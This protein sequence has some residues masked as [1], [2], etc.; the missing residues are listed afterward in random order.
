MANVSKLRPNRRVIDPVAHAQNQAADQVRI[1]TGLQDWVLVQ[2]RLQL[3]AQ[4]FP[5]VFG[6]RH[7]GV[8]FHA[9]TASTLIPQG[10]GRGGDRP[11]KIEPFVVVDYEEEIGEHLVHSAGESALDHSLLVMPANGPTGEERLQLWVFLENVI[12]EA[13][14]FLHN[15]VHLTALVG[16]VQERSRV[17]AGDTLCANIGGRWIGAPFFVIGLCHV[18]KP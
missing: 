18:A 17:D 7:S 5:L 9:D 10:P 15:C 11:K 14:E 12:N 6:Q 1:D 3:L 16:G 2:T 8:D 13:F 4:P